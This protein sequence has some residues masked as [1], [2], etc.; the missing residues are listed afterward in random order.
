M[1]R[2][3]PGRRG[4]PGWIRPSNWYLTAFLIPSG[5]AAEKSADPDEIDA[6]DGEVPE[7]VGLPEESSEESRAPGRATSLPPW[8]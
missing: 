2:P 7:A 4:L 8:A 3:L 6:M 5:S 1:V